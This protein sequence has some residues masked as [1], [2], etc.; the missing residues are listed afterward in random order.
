[1]ATTVDPSSIMTLSDT[2]KTK[3]FSAI[4]ESLAVYSGKGS[5]QYVTETILSQHDRFGSSPIQIN[6]EK[7]GLTFFTRPRLNLSTTSLRQDPILAMLT[8]VDP[9]A[10]MFALRCNLD[11]VFA[12]TTGKTPALSS[13]WVNTESPFCIPLSNAL[14]GMSGW[15]DINVEYET[16]EAGYF[17]E[18]M[19]MVRG[20]DRGRRTYDISCTFRDIQGGFIMALIYYW[21]HA[22]ALQMEG[23]TVAYPD[24]RA[25]NRLN[26]TCSIYRFTLDPSMRTITGWAKATGCF[27]INIPIGEKFNFGPGDSF[28]HTSQQFTVQFK[29][30]NVTY[31]DPRH[32]AAFNHLVKRYAWGGND[33]PSDLVSAPPDAAYNFKGLPYIDL[34]N[35]TNQLH[36]LAKPDSLINKSQ[37][38]VDEILANFTRGTLSPL[39]DRLTAHLLDEVNVIAPTS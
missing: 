4:T 36:W 11:T 29:A 34:I 20:S 25:A 21:L 16:T 10:Q 17:A 26:Y 31:M 2:D 33:R 6:S 32:L 8:T 38:I 9:L 1:M 22:M 14:V 30:N 13:P 15:P 27:P 7:V 3:L 35:G 5:S 18:D 23:I 37:K 24:D 28:I 19:T 12:T 39:T